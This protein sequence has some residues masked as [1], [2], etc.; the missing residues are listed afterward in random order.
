MFS[1]KTI[2]IGSRSSQLATVQA[3]IVAENITRIWPE[4]STEIVFY[5]TVGDKKREDTNPSIR[6]SRDWILEIEHG[7]LHGEI[8]LAVYPGRDV[9]CDIDDHTEIQPILSRAEP[10]DALIIS[11][12]KVPNIQGL[13]DLPLGA[14]VAVPCLMS[15]IQLLRYRND[16]NV[17]PFNG[18]IPTGIKKIKASDNK[19]CAMITG[20]ADM[21]RLGLEDFIS[22]VLPI[23]QF[24]PMVNQGALVSQMRKGDSR[25]SKILR[26]LCSAAEKFCFNAEREAVLCMG[27]SHSSP[28]SVLCTNCGGDRYTIYGAVFF[29]NALSKID[30][31]I[32]GN[33]TSP[34]VLGQQLADKLLSKGVADILCPG[35]ELLVGFS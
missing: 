33:Y 8:D 1:G 3:Q 24:P 9:P 22:D 15:K 20:K 12:T 4:I 25:V 14:T 23:E 31:S 11:H 2:K 26:P 6:E 27:A 18:S 5:T 29:M 7:L 28:I 35:K 34:E 30:Q 21:E 32:S 10:N 13:S 17:V 19:V 16:L